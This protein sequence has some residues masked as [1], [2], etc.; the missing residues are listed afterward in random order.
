[1]LSVF[2]F[3]YWGNVFWPWKW[4]PWVLC[5]F[6]A[7]DFWRALVLMLVY[8]WNPGIHVEWEVTQLGLASFRTQSRLF[9]RLPRISLQA[10]KAFML[11]G[12]VAGSGR[13][14]SCDL[15]T[16][17]KKTVW[18]LLLQQAWWGSP[19][20]GGFLLPVSK[21]PSVLCIMLIIYLGFF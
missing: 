8:L 12:W 3:I 15:F 7:S 6:M 19:S 4:N 1:M 18:S 11:R 13:S 5:L 10:R 21:L 16:L 17:S 9:P 20:T 2:V 14:V